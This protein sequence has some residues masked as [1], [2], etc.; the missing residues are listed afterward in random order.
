VYTQLT[1]VALMEGM[2]LAKT[3]ALNQPTKPDY[4][5]IPSAVFS[6]PEIAVVVSE[7]CGQPTTVNCH[8]LSAVM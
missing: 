2:A 8:S 6:H 7:K 3:I 1:P 4:A 5:A